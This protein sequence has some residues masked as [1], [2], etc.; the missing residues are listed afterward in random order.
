MIFGFAISRENG[1]NDF[2]VI[3]AENEEQA[4]RDIVDE[5][6]VEPSDVVMMSAGEALSQFRG[7]AL[8]SPLEA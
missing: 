8:L 4:L 3:N 5:A 2:G 7:M 6:E 1:A